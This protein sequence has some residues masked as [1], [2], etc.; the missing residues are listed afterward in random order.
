M[1]KKKIVYIPYEDDAKWLCTFNDMMTLLLTFFVLLL[2][3]SSL[4]AK[5]IADLQEEMIN[6]L[7]VMEAG[8]MQEETVI[9]KVLHIN[10]IG[11][12]MK[13]F[14]NILPPIEE[15][16]EIDDRI[17]SEYP[18]ELFKNFA[19][20]RE[21]GIR[22]V[23]SL[24]ALF[25]QF[26]STLQDDWYEPGVTILKQ[27]RGV[28]LQMQDSILFDAGTDEL[29]ADARVLL[30]QVADV[31]QQCSLSVSIE[32]HT[33]A[34]PIRTARFPSNWE[35]SV[36]RAVSVA[37]YLIANESIAPERIGVTGFADTR[38]IAPNDTAASRR[39]NRRIEIILSGA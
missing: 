2:S 10:E 35:L 14:K 13:I 17:D 25:N 12:R 9:E 27:Q 6:A 5:K 24:D 32:A 7:G 36:A 3:M 31:M 37:E 34:T 38:P 29:G 4:D 18:D 20:L 28:V 15:G 8:Y 11:K 19:V 22:Q 23:D 21:E 1:A 30:S 26:R 39:K 33:D 16:R